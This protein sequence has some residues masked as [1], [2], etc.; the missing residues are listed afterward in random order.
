[1]T[2]LRIPRISASRRRELDRL[3]HD[4]AALE[5]AAICR[6]MEQL[7]EHISDFR[8]T[9]FACR[10]SGRG[11][12]LICTFLDRINDVSGTGPYDLLCTVQ[13][14]LHLAGNLICNDL[15]YVEDEID[16][17]APAVGAGE[18]VRG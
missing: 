14:T 18:A 5:L 7:H 3:A 10:T 11:R 17:A 13:A 12:C 16:E 8:A 6:A 9:H 1:M 15:P 2:D 4:P